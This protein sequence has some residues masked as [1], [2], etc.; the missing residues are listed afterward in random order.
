MLLGRSGS[1]LVVLRTFM[2]ET[3]R[4]RRFVALSNPA[5]YLLSAILTFYFEIQNGKPQ[6]LGPNQVRTR[7]VVSTMMA[8][9]IC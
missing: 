1:S 7:G 5:E 6:A 2:L 3:R 4:T 8:F 9:R